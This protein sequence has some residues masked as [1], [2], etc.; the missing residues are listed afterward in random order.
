MKKA[1]IYV[2]IPFCEKKCPYCDFYSRSGTVNLYQEYTDMLCS[3]IAKSDYS[4]DYTADTLYFGGGTP[5][6]IGAER[7]AQ[8]TDTVC[9]IFRLDK[10]SS[11]ITVEVNPSKEDVDF[12]KLRKSGVNR[13][14]IGL[15]SSDDKELKI[16][17]RLH[18][19]KQAAECITKAQN[20]GFKNISL[21]LMLAI[22]EQT[23]E[24]LKRSVEFCVSTGAVHISAYILKIEPNT[25]FYKKRNSLSL[26]D[27]DTAA[28]YYEYLCEL[29]KL[30]GF[31]HY[32]ISN[33]CKRGYESRH[34]LKYWHDEEYIGFGASAHSFVGGKRFYVPR[35]IKSFYN[36]ETVQ[37]GN[38]GDEEEYIMLALRLREG[39]VYR[40]F[41]EILGFEFPCKYKLRAERL[42]N[43]GLIEISK[44]G[45]HLTQRG[46]LL[47][48][49]VISQILQ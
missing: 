27:D 22:P 30:Y 43:T 44:D 34:N 45:F 41:E 17:G 1:G 33:F 7:I 42:N 4:N 46:F 26:P 31:E 2:H 13:I 18:D 29:M 40:K 36:D 8:I 10:D 23:K 25:V 3:K 48:N 5:S 19:S 38:G 9:R 14:S 6:L 35:N 28:E 32:E 12:K 47:S 37:D 49:A 16:L 15:Q 11:E 21:D 39:I 20:A 24:S